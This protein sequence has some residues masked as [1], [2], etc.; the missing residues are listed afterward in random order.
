MY[1]NREACEALP[2]TF[3]S[4]KSRDLAFGLGNSGKRVSVLVAACTGAEQSTHTR[5]ADQPQVMRCR[6]DHRRE[7]QTSFREAD[8]RHS[9]LISELQ[10]KVA[11]FQY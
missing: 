11:H 9:M 8:L 5:G 6:E 7:R 3:P 10:H 4:P 1:Y 2:G